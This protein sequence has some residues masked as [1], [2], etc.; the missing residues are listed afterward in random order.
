MDIMWSEAL[1]LMQRALAML[2]ESQAPAQIGAHL[3]LAIIRLEEH[4]SDASAAA[5]EFRRNIRRSL[6]D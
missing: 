6:P 1:A 3:D 5:E 4:L 2:D